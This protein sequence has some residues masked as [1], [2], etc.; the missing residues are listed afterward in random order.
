MAEGLSLQK[1]CVECGLHLSL[2]SLCDSSAARGIMNRS[3]T[4]RMKHLEVKHLW[5]QEL[6]A[7]KLL[8]VQWIARQENA[9]DVFDTFHQQE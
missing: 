9:A 5:V 7:K 2:H 1:L 4:G 6:V 3:G 8:T